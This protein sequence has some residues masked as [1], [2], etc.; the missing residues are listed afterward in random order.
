[1][2]NVF[3]SYSHK[4]G[5][6]KDHLVR[7]LR[8]LQKEVLLDPWHDEQIG[9][10]DQWHSKIR[11][12]MDRAD[13]AV[14]L[15]T[16]NSLSS[17]F[18]LNEEVPYLLERQ[19]KDGLR[20]IPVI[21]EAC[22]WQK[23]SWLSPLQVRPK[24]GRPL[25]RFKGKLN[26]ELTRICEE[27]LDFTQETP[28]ADTKPR[29]SAISPGISS[30]L[31]ALH[32][33]PPPPRDFT[34]RQE[35][36]ASLK[37]KL[38]QGGAGAI[39]GFRG[40]GGVGKTTL[41]LKLAEE[42]TPLYPDAQIYLDLKGVDLQPL[43]PAQAM[44]HVIRSFHPEVQLPE[45][46]MQLEG[47]YR[48]VLHGKRTILLMDN[49]S[50]EGRAQV[51]PLIPPA[52]SLLLVTSRFHFTLPGFVP[53]DLDEMSQKEARDLLLRIDERIG[54]D[55]DEI[56][57]L[58]GYLPLALR[59]AGS[60]LA[61]RPTL[62]PADYI[63]R[64][65]EGK[66]RLDGVDASLHTS[67]DLLDEEQRRLWRWLGVFP[68]TFDLAAAAA[69]WE[70]DEDSAQKELD[71]LNRYSLVEWDSND[72]RFRL[73]D[74]AREFAVVL[75]EKNE[76]EEA[77]VK[78]AKHYL[79]VLA[80]A[81]NLFEEGGEQILVG[82]RMFDAERRNIQAGQ[83]WA[84]KHSAVSEEA[85]YLCSGYPVE[86]TY[87]LYTRFHPREQIIW[88][89][90]ALEAAR[91]LGERT[92]E[93]RHLGS[94]GLAYTYLGQP[95]RAIELYE[96]VLDLARESADRRTEGQ[97]LGNLGNCHALLGD[98]RRA[99][100]FYEDDLAIAREIVDRRGEE[101]T[102]GN[103]GV[104]YKNLGEPHRA[105]EICEQQL[106]IA[107]EIGD[108]LGE[109]NALGNLG[110][111][112]ADLGEPHR[113]I[114]FY[115]QHLAIAREIGDRIGEAN[116]NW[117]LGLGYEE[118]GDLQRAADLMQVFVDF[119]REIGHLDAEK[120]AAYVEAIRARLREQES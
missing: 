6:W 108:R 72:R 105:I 35:E 30:P 19:A 107:R 50:R 47:L 32:Q 109:A 22:A 92:A 45:D 39:F 63:R 17:D 100:E 48:S 16:S 120:D 20:F 84:V 77:R 55:A 34:G 24:D 38:T 31:Q 70:L 91:R 3:I 93:M 64:L 51:E 12:A 104:A 26:S 98:P 36:L 11:E 101:H 43:T 53:K 8:V 23:I 94:L 21:A 62:S 76:Q 113:A 33:L 4:D 86:G 28:K 85:A 116:A 56:A 52:G 119:R 13:A 7:H 65:K 14:L 59:L 80:R 40:M 118:E 89:E 88:R 54:A 68:D 1:M 74:L 95:L 87:I 61:E 110:I 10:G 96:Q 115:E 90:A 73:H 29:D 66:E 58:C 9:P 81:D 83:A 15:V 102:L 97:T 112:Y 2:P 117:N 75:F 44:A 69:I 79:G 67:Y 99:I 37:E 71:D 82:L 25:E 41:A 18:I 57:Q 114:E 106:A 103:M 42:L 49:A 111:A 5:R 78:H 27:I 60:A 46:P